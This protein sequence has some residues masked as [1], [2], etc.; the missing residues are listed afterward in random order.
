MIFLPKFNDFTD[1]NT[2]N[3]D[4]NNNENNFIDMQNDKK[5]IL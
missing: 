1:F 5:F 4:Y 2:D 3:K